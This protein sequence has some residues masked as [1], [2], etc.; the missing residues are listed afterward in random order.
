[1]AVTITATAL[2]QELGLDA[3]EADELAV[4][5]RLLSV[6]SAIVSKYAPDAPDALSDEAVLRYAGY[7]Y[8]STASNYG[9][10]LKQDVAGIGIEYPTNHGLAF[11]NSGAKSLLSPWKVRHA[12]KCS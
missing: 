5:T 2:A 8:G 4:A 9:S 1:M 10:H 3:S 12:G 11:R 6:G 7:L